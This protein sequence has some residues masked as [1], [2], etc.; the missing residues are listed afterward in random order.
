MSYTP[1]VSVSL[2]AK[3]GAVPEAHFFDSSR[4]GNGLIN[5][6]GTG[7]EAPTLYLPPKAADA[8]AYLDGL[9]RAACSLRNEYVE[10]AVSHEVAL[11]A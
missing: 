1:S 7:S 8:I 9:I 6:D 3:A 11:A 4:H 5:L 10:W 2:S